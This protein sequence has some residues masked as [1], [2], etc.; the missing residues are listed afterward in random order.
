MLLILTFVIY[1]PLIDVLIFVIDNFSRLRMKDFMFDVVIKANFTNHCRSYLNIKIKAINISILDPT[2]EKMCPCDC[3][4]KRRLEILSTNSDIPIEELK[5][6][7]A[8]EIEQL[9]KSLAVDVTKLASSRRKKISAGD[10]RK[11]SEQIGYVGAIIIA[12]VFGLVILID[13]VAIKRFYT[14]F[15]RNVLG[16]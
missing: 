10:K 7:L 12:I 1:F 15:R 16:R 14:V 6:Q 5:I 3:E 4:F 11:S 9:K 8:P 2:A 13:I